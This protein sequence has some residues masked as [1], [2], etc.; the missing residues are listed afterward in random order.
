MSNAFEV[1]NHGDL[2]NAIHNLEAVGRQYPSCKLCLV[3]CDG[4]DLK[5]AKHMLGVTFNKSIKLVCSEDI[6]SYHSNIAEVSRKLPNPL[7]ET[8]RD[9]LTALVF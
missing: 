4:K 3:V 9:T 5:A 8:F 1:Q 2:K 7:W 6:H